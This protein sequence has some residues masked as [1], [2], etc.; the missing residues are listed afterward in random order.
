MQN[1]YII[2]VHS[3]VDLI[4]NSSTE[5]F[6]SANNKSAETVQDIINGILALGG[7]TVKAEDLFTFEIVVEDPDSY[8]TKF[9]PVKSDKG[10][11]II[12]EC[13][14]GNGATQHIRLTPLVDSPEA[15][16]IAKVM[17]NLTELF[18]IEESYNG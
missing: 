8:P 18:T 5:L 16:K 4:T 7:S 11:E 3:F 17:S 13:D 6:V 10:K 1:S 14:G 15:K 12:D 9:Y 2:R